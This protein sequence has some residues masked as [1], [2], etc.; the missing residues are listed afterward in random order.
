MIQ[1][2]LPVILTYLSVSFDAVTKDIL[3][4]IELLWNAIAGECIGPRTPVGMQRRNIINQLFF[5]E[6]SN[7]SLNRFD[8]NTHHF[9]K[10]G[11]SHVA[12]AVPVPGP[13]HTN[14]KKLFPA[15][16]SVLPKC[17]VEPAVTD[18]TPIFHP[19]ATRGRGVLSR[20]SA[21]EA[22]GGVNPARCFSSS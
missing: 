8:R 6:P 5:E 12:G 19:A 15:I 11:H 2:I 22:T 7:T 4:P 18:L 17:P 3:S 9:G 14:Q 21:G 1:K 20:I 16:A 10:A 13:S